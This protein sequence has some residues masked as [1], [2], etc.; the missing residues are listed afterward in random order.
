VI[1]DR[2]RIA[3][4]IVL[5]HCKARS[6]SS[7]KH[8]TTSPPH[9]PPC[10]ASSTRSTYSRPSQIHVVQLHVCTGLSLASTLRYGSAGRSCRTIASGM[11]WQMRCRMSNLA[12]R[13]RPI[14]PSPNPQQI[15]HRQTGRREHL[16]GPLQ[17]PRR[18]FK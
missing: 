7:Q 14:V 4:Q 15:D 9:H 16:A 1:F 10:R 3:R 8:W 6:H 11:R 2:A 5:V 18:C 13:A 17:S 12:P